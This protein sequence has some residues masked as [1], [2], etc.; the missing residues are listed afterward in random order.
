M[1]ELP[2]VE[3][4]RRGIAPKILGQTITAVLIRQP[5]LRWPV[6]ASLAEELPGLCFRNIDRRGKYLLLDAEQ[7][8]LLIHLGM[9]GSL[10]IVP[11]GTAANKHDHIDILFSN[12]IV[13]RY[14]DPRRFGCMLWVTQPVLQHPLLENL[15]PEPLSDEF[16]GR[17]LKAQGRGKKI[18]VKNFIMD[19][20]VVVGIG[21]IY[22]NEAL[23]NAAI[24]PSCQAGKI[25]ITRYR[26]LVEQLKSVLQD[27]IH[28]GGTTLRDFTGSDGKPGYFKQSLKVY[29]RGGEPCIQCDRVLTEIRIGQ[30][31]TVYCKH[32]QN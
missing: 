14:T 10:R 20:S 26:F 17:Y 19:S 30:R 3:T 2:E 29:G 16:D 7:G 18:A 21:N 5:K 12:N 1:P 9:S 13:L 24:R 22:A 15:G 23:F 32:C 4:T 25:S 8:V 6:T 11:L 27:A 31:S 28:V